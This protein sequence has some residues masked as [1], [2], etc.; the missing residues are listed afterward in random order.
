MANARHISSSLCMLTLLAITGCAS[1]PTQHAHTHYESQSHASR[2]TD[3]ALAAH[4]PVEEKKNEK[5]ARSSESETPKRA[6]YTTPGQPYQS[7]FIL[8]TATNIAIVEQDQAVKESAQ[9]SVA[10]V[11]G[12]IGRLGLTAPPTRLAGRVTSRPGLQDGPATGLGFAPAGRNVFT[13]QFNPA[14]GPNGRCAELVRAGFRNGSLANCQQPM[15]RRR[16]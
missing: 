3:F 5:S 10:S 16:R 14:S 7:I 6:T 11:S 9:S 4:R 1:T 12:N 8:I 15:A 2:N 13:P